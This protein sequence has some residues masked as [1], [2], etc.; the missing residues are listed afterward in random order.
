MEF[1]SK[2]IRCYVCSHHQFALFD[3]AKFTFALEI[4]YLK[5]LKLC[6]TSNSSG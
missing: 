4:E 2:T 3:I 1:F 5:H 6:L